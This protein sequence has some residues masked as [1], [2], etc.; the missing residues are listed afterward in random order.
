MS[1][2]LELPQ[3]N[4]YRDHA[5]REPNHPA[6]CCVVNGQLFNG[7]LDDAVLDLSRFGVLLGKLERYKGV[8]DTFILQLLGLGV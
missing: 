8:R 7:L 4:A 2:F 5:L 6:I 1:V 3:D